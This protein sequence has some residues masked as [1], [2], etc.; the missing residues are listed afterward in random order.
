MKIF[1]G[2]VILAFVL[3]IAGLISISELNKINKSV[4]EMI[5]ENY[6]SIEASNHMLESLEQQNTALVLL[7]IGDK[8]QSMSILYSSD[9]TFRSAYEKAVQSI[10]ISNEKELLDTIALTYNDF[11]RNWVDTVYGNLPIGKASI[12]L[13]NL[14]VSLLKI[15]EPIRTLQNINQKKLIETAGNIESKSRQAAMP[16][17][18]AILAAVIFALIFNFLLNY[19]LVT[20]IL[21]ITKGL[22]NTLKYYTPFNVEIETNDELMDLKNAIH[23]FVATH[24]PIKS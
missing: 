22:E 4:K 12:T 9:T 14:H 24:S 3:L 20:P 2:F 17:I 21:R 11:R 16:G 13:K 19:Y 6:Q 23:S 1:S 18:V 15:K 7:F 8:E 5:D 10:T